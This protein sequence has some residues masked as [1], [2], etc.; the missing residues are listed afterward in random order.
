[1]TTATTPVI[2]NAMYRTPKGVAK[3]CTKVLDAN[4]KHEGGHSAAQRKEY[5]PIDADD[6]GTFAIVEDPNERKL[7]APK[8]Q[9]GV[10]AEERSQTLK[11]L[12]KHNTALYA[13][14]VKTGKPAEFAKSP[15]G[16]IRVTPDKVESMTF[17]IRK[18]AQFI[19]KGCEFGDKGVKEKNTGRVVI[20]WRC[21]DKRERKTNGSTNGAA[22]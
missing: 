14:W 6:L 19:G 10:K 1:M 12:D 21:I 15:L 5:K 7:L 8:T 11:D 20:S 18:S 9:R 4:G 16:K 22:A 3:N 2:C 17:L 13:A